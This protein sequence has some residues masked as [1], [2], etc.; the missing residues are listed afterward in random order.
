[1]DP[2]LH[3]TPLS[4]VQVL[5]GLFRGGQRLASWGL[6]LPRARGEPCIA[7]LQGQLLPVCPQQLS[8]SSS[9]QTVL[10]SPF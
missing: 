4:R 3:P 1:M 5:G 6:G 10:R 2:T 9:E 8:G 7:H